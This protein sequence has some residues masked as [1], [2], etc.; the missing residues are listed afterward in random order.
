[1]RLNHGE[2]QGS[3]TDKPNMEAHF[4]YSIYTAIYSTINVSPDNCGVGNTS[5]LEQLQLEAARIVTGLPVFT[6]LECLYTETGWQSLAERRK[7]RRLQM[8]Y[9]MQNHVAP[10]YLSRLVPPKVQSLSNYPLRNGDDLI[11]PF[12]RLSITN[13]S[14]IP[15]TIREWNAVDSSIRCV[16]SIGAFKTALLRGAGLQ[17]GSVPKYYAFGPRKL[18]IILTE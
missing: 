5:R 11:L 14:F 10:D 1:M 8:F 9:N 16:N 12:C 7:W 4:I 15:S 13:N 2:M 18:N 3:N 17:S 6:K